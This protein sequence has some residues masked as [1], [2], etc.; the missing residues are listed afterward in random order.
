MAILKA[1]GDRLIDIGNDIISLSNEFD[2]II[3]DLFSKICNIPN[4]AW[5]GNSAARYVNMAKVDKFQYK[6][7]AN[8]LKSY[9]QIYKNTGEQ[10][11]SKVNKWEAN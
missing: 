8:Q 9:G 11:N 6:S 1:D 7:L 5:S 10:I 2:G 4:V 3:E